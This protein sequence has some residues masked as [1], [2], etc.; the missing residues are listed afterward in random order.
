MEARP[1]TSA[2]V[3]A[4]AE[5]QHRWDIAWFGASEHSTE[6]V[7]EY[8]G[9]TDSLAED[10][11]L[12]FD[13]GRLVGAGFRWGSDTLLLTDPDAEPGPLHDHLLPWF[14]QR[15]GLVEALNR[16]ERLRAAL[17]TSGWHHHKSAFELTRPVTPDFELPEPSWPAGIT[18][19]D[20]DP[21]D[22]AAVHRLIYVDAG[23]AEVPGHPD[24]TFEDWHKIFVTEHTKPEQQVI[25]W[26]AE[27]IVG[28]AMG[29]TFD[30]GTG[31][32]AQLA[33]A[34]AERGKGLGR[35]MLIEALRRRMAGGATALGL[36]VQA[37]NRHALGMYL[38]AGL[39]IDREWMQYA[40]R[41]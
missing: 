7:A 27:R 39:A 14:A 24:R 9:Y 4:V 20:F 21:A 3:P 34:K 40:Y 17:E 10:S 23:W 18:V 29:R 22:A 36:G 38:D 16:D 25:A 11:R 26:R 12:L 19:R 6:E 37:T 32:V 15:P 28:V 5:L 8:F 35:A 13:G 30:D 33:T 2:D 31:W 1:A 41:R